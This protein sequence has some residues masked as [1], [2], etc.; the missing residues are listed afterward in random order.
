MK[1]REAAERATDM[2][3]SSGNRSGGSESAGDGTAQQQIEQMKEK[4][5]IHLEEIRRL[6][7]EKIDLQAVTI[8]QKEKLLV[9][10]KE[11]G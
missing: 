9:R 3:G 5:R 6:L 7:H 1:R 11:F 10:E 2:L 4:D 8:E